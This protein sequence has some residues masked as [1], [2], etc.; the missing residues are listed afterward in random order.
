MTYDDDMIKRGK[1][2]EPIQRWSP[3]TD[4]DGD[5]VMAKVAEGGDWVRWADHVAAMR[6]FEGVKE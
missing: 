1:V 2:L 5:I 6:A 3:F 4:E